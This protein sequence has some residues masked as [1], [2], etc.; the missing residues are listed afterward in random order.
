ML[1]QPAKGHIY[2]GTV[3]MLH[4][5]EYVGIYDT[6]G[7]SMNPH[8]PTAEAPIGASLPVRVGPAA[9][10]HDVSVV[11]DGVPVVYLAD[12]VR[13]TAVHGPPKAL[14]GVGAP[15][16][17]GQVLVQRGAGAVCAGTVR[18]SG[19]RTRRVHPQTRVRVNSSKSGAREEQI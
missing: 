7:Q 13:A 3:R 14:H 15:V 2:I 18:V 19:G 5:P 4:I 16:Q 17:L 1:K 8:R 11:S 6:S 12:V 10:T 9:C